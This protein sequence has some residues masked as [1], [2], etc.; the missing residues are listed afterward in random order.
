MLN[1]LVYEGIYLYLTHF[2]FS[3]DEETGSYLFSD[4]EEGGASI[5]LKIANGNI[6]Y[7]ELFENSNYADQ[8]K[9]KL[10]FY[11]Y[12][13]TDVILPNVILS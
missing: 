3:Y 13:S 12:N 6:V 8:Q 2:T 10:Y 7:F 1:L 4:T 9:L 5:S 11:D